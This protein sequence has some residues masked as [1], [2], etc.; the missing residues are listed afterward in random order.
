VSYRIGSALVR[1][2]IAFVVAASL[3][4][5]ADSPAS[6]APL[7]WEP[8]EL[9][10]PIELTITS[11]KQ[12]Y[13]LND[14]R[15]YR[16]R[17][18]EV[19]RA[20]GGLVLVGGH[21]VVII[22]G[23]IE[24]PDS[25]STDAL[26]RRGMYLKNQTGTIHVEGV[27]IAG[28]NLAEGINLDQRRGATVQ[29]QNI[30]VDEVHGTAGGHH[31]D[32]LQTW[33]GPKTLRINGLTGTTQYQG[34]FLLPHQ[35]WKYAVVENWDIRN[36]DITSTAGGYTLWKENSH[37]IA[38]SNI[39]LHRTYTESKW[40]FMWPNDAAWPGAT[41]GLPTVD[42]VSGLPGVNYSLTGDDGSVPTTGGG[43]ASTG[44]LGE[45]LPDAG[46]AEGYW[47]VASDGGIFSY[48]DARFF[49]S[50][51]GMRLNQPVVG[52]AATPSANG[53]WL[54]ASDG[55]IFA[56]GDAGF[57]G[58][59]GSI[60]LNQP[61]VGM[62]STPSGKGYWL[63]AAD[64]GIFAYGDAAFHGSTGSVKLNKPIVGMTATPSGQGYWLV[65]S[66]GG[67]FAYGDA[68][69]FG[70]TGSIKLNQPIT[71]MTSTPSGN[72]YWLIA[73]DGGI[74]A[75]GDAAF[76]GSAVGKASGVATTIQATPDGSGY[77]I[78]TSTGAVVPAG[79]AV[80][81]GSFKGSLSKPV[82]GAT[83]IR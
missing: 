70:S 78:M 58:S 53:Y 5:P 83:A 80:N 27:H 26:Q 33:A 63:V 6:A 46:G 69:F 52:M 57:H 43:A 25:A 13:T 19:L 76:H 1:T 18:G 30:L 67:I 31:A 22:G 77:W 42:P 37:V 24:V 39:T 45:A 47:L 55:G 48:G 15:D 41:I 51:G 54:V 49:G 71:N 4:L 35:H 56:Y 82:V 17:F 62:A 79:D 65:A 8:P 2:A 3:M 44:E 21:N 64:G 50:T 34:L 73:A 20:P 75:Y 81:Y 7:A 9:V 36:V 11:A 72:G 66:D 16:I 28:P 38:N 59:T 12:S 10:N 23:K 61:I 29:F 32:I 74:F 40:G 14:S 60:N 68:R